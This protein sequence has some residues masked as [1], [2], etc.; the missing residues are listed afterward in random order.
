ML[1]L[2][3]APAARDIALAVTPAKLAVGD[4]PAEPETVTA[5]IR[6]RPALRFEVDRARAEASTLLAGLLA[7]AQA[8]E[9][10]AAILG[11]DFI[12]ADFTA[13]EWR[14]AAADGLSLLC[15]ANRCVEGWSGI[16]EKDG[17]LT[18]F[19]AANLARLLRDPVIAAT[20]RAAIEAPVHAETAEKNA[21]APLPPGEG[22]A[23]AASAPNAA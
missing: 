12:A 17:K 10:A 8:A 16:A 5:S 1:I 2:N 20:V 13:T 7:G 4:R 23:A 6:V 3:D 22:A 21:S 18:E 9:R 15:L 11:Q 14:A 19:N